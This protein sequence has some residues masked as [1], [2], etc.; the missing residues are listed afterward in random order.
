MAKERK[1]IKKLIE[2][3]KGIKEEILKPKKLFF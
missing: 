2:Y 1:Y 3:L